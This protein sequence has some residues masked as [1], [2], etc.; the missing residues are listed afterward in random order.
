MSTTKNGLVIKS[1]GSWYRVL[2]DDKK[3]VECKFKGKFRIKG[4]RSTN[5]IAVGDRV[6]FITETSD[7]TGL[8]IEIEDR[9]NYIIRRSTNLSKETQILAAN[10]DLAFLLVTIAYPKHRIGFIDRF[11]ASAEAYRIPVQ[12]I[13]NKI[14]CYSEKH[15][16]EMQKLIDIYEKVGYPCIT[17]SALKGTNI[18]LIKEK[19]AGKT[20]IFA[21]N[22]G[23]GKSTLANAIDPSLNLKT[24]EIS[25]SHK[26]GKHTTTFAQ[27]FELKNGGFLIDTPGIKG[28]GVFDMYKEEIFHFFPEIFRI[29]PMCRYNNCTHNHEPGCAVKQ[30]VKDGE[31]SE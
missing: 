19:L 4:I 30:A 18:Q 23:V 20:T 10:I 9:K 24:D 11:L 27:M 13:F 12:I 2:T 15:L 14:D 28:F 25:Q 6:K 31:I 8:I 16:E 21:G 22:S 26:K 1:T 29:S 17:A 5:P 3:I 7:G